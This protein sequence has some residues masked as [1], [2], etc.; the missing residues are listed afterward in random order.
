MAPSLVPPTGHPQAPL[1]GLV[2][3][4]TQPGHLHRHGRCASWMR[5]RAGSCLTR[6]LLCTPPAPRP[7]GSGGVA[8]SPAARLRQG[9]VRTPRQGPDEPAPTFPRPRPRPRASTGSVAAR[10]PGENSGQNPRTSSLR[11]DRTARPLS[12]AFG[13]PHRDP[14]SVILDSHSFPGELCVLTP[15]PRQIVLTG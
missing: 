12:T 7:L 11:S 2:V 8:V 13:R 14:H 6:L 15:R 9:W 4:N 3:G 1:P 10:G 5:Q